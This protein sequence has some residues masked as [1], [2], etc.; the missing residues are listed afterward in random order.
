MQDLLSWKDKGSRMPLLL[1]GARQTGK[2]WLLK[3]FGRKNY[4]NVIHINLEAQERFRKVFDG[5]LT[6][7]VIIENIEVL[8]MQKIVPGKTLLIFDEVQSCERALTS[9]KSFCEE[10]PE[11]HVAAAGSLLGVAI[12]RE[13]FSFPVGKVDEMQLFPLDFNEFLVA[14]GRE[15]LARV[16]QEHYVQCEPMEAA[17]HEEALAWWRK[18]MFTGGMPAAVNAYSESGSLLDVEEPQHRIINEYVAD[19]AKYSEP[20][21][22]VKIRGCYNSIPAQLA[23]EN[24]KFQYKVVQRGGSAAMFGESIEWL[25][26][27]GAVLKC[28][29]IEQGFLPINAYSDLSDFK[30]YMADTGL[31]T[32]KTQMPPAILLS[33]FAEDN[34]FMGAM[35]EN[36]VAQSL[37]PRHS[38]YY[39]QS[40]NTAEIDFVAQI[41][42]QVVPIEV[43][44]GTHTKSKSLDLFIKKYNIQKAIRLSQKNFGVTG[45]V[46]SVPL[47]A[48]SC[49]GNKENAH[50][51]T[52]CRAPLLKSHIADN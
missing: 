31:L 45:P 49:I 42:G 39:W 19:M 16:I 37:A 29:K 8:S 5:D 13:H 38:L 18:Y 22:T 44:K 1:N 21:T 24:K 33:P 23:K 47:Y 27:S 40:N 2:T 7:S 10:A 43:K 35:V 30:L 17:L 51:F 50:A 14:M 9:L 4:D 36:Y 46:I 20:A 28:Q 3:E 26:Q 12:H 32:N 6:P 52:Q 15:E 11:Y 48:A 41:N 34:T 25:V